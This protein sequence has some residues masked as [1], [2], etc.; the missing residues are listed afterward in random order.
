MRV[1]M[2]CANCHSHSLSF[3]ERSMEADFSGIF[4]AD[5]KILASSE[6]LSGDARVE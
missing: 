3:T 1:V 5:F 2:G 4:G 6:L